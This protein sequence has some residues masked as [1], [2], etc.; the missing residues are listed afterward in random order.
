MQSEANNGR[1]TMRTILDGMCDS[2]VQGC[3]AVAA[4]TVMACLLFQ[5]AL[6]ASR[7]SAIS[8]QVLCS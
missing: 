7:L 2:L 5:F 1:L 4:V 3:M 6:Q 8:L